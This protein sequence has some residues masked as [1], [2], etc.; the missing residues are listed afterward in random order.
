MDGNTLSALAITLQTGLPPLL[1]GEP[2]IGK[3]SLVRAIAETLQV[4]LRTVI[5]AI[6]DPTDFKGLPVRD[7]DRTRYLPPDW[8]VELREKVRG[9]LF[10]DEISAAAPS[11]QNALFRVVLERVVGDNLQLPDTIMIAAAA[12]PADQLLSGWNLTPPLANRFVHFDCQLVA[13]EWTKGMLEGW[14]RRPVPVL[15]ADWRQRHYPTM[16]ALIA[17]Y[18]KA[19]GT[20]VQLL[21]KDET[22]AGRAW[23]SGRSWDMA[24]LCLAGARSVNAGM[25]VEVELVKG[26]VGSG[27]ALGFSEWFTKANLPDPE[28]LLADPLKAK[29]PDQVDILLVVLAS[30]TST[31]LQGNTMERWLAGWKLLGRALKQTNAV[32]IPAIFA[33]Q[34][35]QNENR[36]R[37]ID[38]TNLPSELSAFLPVLREAGLLG[39]KRA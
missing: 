2:G 31:I 12:N 38:M 21:P 16:R 20:E 17:G 13:A 33:I 11:V 24:A 9:L 25:E 6:C 36:P 7:G 10:L 26:C 37:G 29:L 34:L 30:V 18:I 5:A 14:P 22:Q 23:P 19:R 4:P 3:T 1:W 32:D 28:D 8:A 27:P 39:S 35:A 15:P